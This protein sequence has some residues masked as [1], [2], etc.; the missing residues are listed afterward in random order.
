MAHLT[1]AYFKFFDEL[2][3]NNNKEW[4]DKNRE[5]YENDVK[6]PFRKLV[7]DLTERLSKDLPE[8]N[9]DVSKAV[10]RINRDIRFAKD[11]SPY[12]INMAAVFSRKGTKDESYPGFYLH[13]GADEIMLGGGKYFCSK[14]DIAAIRQEIYYNHAAFKKVVNDRAFKEKFGTLQGDK[15]KVLEPDYKEFSRQE[16]LIANKQFWFYTNL[17]RK[18]VTT[19]NFDKLAYNYF[20]SAFKLNRFLWEAVNNQ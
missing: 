5:R 13:I 15:S 11:K 3:K 1:P 2:K 6:K 14:E 16:A 12:K 20:K 17:T 4:F 9:R 7:E 18:E 10:F 8:L 19:E